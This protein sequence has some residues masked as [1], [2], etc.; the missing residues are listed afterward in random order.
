MNQLVHYYS[1]AA[2]DAALV[3][4]TKQTFTLT[5]GAGN[6][7]KRK[8]DLYIT[9]G[10]SGIGRGQ[11]RHAISHPQCGRPGQHSGS[12]P[13]PNEAAFVTQFNDMMEQPQ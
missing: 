1:P 3:N 5:H 13:G 11:S 9:G 8:H 12:N 4:R 2:R 7:I 6:E 10:G